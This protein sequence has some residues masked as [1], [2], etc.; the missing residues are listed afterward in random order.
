MNCSRYLKRFIV[1]ILIFYSTWIFLTLCFISKE[2]YTNPIKHAG[3]TNQYQQL[4][5]L[6]TEFIPVSI[7][8]NKDSRDVSFRSHPTNSQLQQHVSMSVT[9]ID[10]LSNLWNSLFFDTFVVYKMYDQL[11]TNTNKHSI[12]HPKPKAPNC[13]YIASLRDYFDISFEIFLNHYNQHSK[14]SNKYKRLIMSIRRKIMI[15]Y[16]HFILNTDCFAIDNNNINDG[17]G[18]TNKDVFDEKYYRLLNLLSKMYVKYEILSAK[19]IYF[20]I[21]VSKSMGTSICDTFRA[22]ET[23]TLMGACNHF[24]K[25]MAEKM[26]P[27]MIEHQRIAGN[28]NLNFENLQKNNSNINIKNSKFKLGLDVP[29]TCEEIETKVINVEQIDMMAQEDPLVPLRCVL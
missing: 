26:L 25:S 17:V 13:T 19:L 5:S 12:K 7:L 18:V 29:L 8:H 16:K 28:G 21:H 20:N 10:D 23:N 3:H 2:F 9:T 27:R 1:W 11:E 14:T 15:I 22:L 24:P 4:G 6:T